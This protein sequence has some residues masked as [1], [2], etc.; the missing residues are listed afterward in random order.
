M[1]IAKVFDPYTGAA[2]GNL[3]PPSGGASLF[4]LGTVVDLTDGTWTLYDPLG[5]IQSVSF[6]G[7]KN[8]VTFNAVGGSNDH[9]WATNTFTADAPRWY[10]ALEIDGNAMD[11]DTL[12]SMQVSGTWDYTVRDFRPQLIAGLCLNPTT[13]TRADIL[14]QGFL[15]NLNET[16]NPAFGCW[17]NTAGSVTGTGLASISGQYLAQY[18]ARRGGYGICTALDA[19]DLWLNYI[20]RVLALTL[21]ST[22]TVY[23][24][25]GL[26][27]NSASPILLNDQTAFTLTTS[28]IKA[29]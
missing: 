21:T 6:G 18:G 15:S 4:D 12:V 23:E 8:T 5:A 13:T 2:N 25:I 16:G 17:A 22:A 1:P 14:G 19:S 29:K 11:S 26:G 9:V 24:I 20:Q 27:T 28:M 10:R 3:P 7:S